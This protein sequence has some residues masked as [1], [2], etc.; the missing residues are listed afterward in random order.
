MAMATVVHSM[1]LNAS[2]VTKGHGQIEREHVA[3]HRTHCH[4]LCH[5]LVWCLPF[6]SRSLYSQLRCRISG[7]H[8]EHHSPKVVDLPQAY[9]IL[10]NDL[11]LSLEASDPSSASIQVLHSQVTNGVTH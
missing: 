9:I 1:V 5:V 11:Y 7:S 2:N 8:I 4:H 6:D 10:Y 3:V